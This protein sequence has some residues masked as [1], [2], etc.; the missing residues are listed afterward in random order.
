[1]PSNST[2]R[3]IERFE[4]R[5]EEL[6]E[7][8]LTLKLGFRWPWSKR[9]PDKLSL[10]MYQLDAK[11]H[12]GRSFFGNLSMEEAKRFALELRP[13]LSNYKLPFLPYPEG[14]FKGNPAVIGGSLALVC[15]LE[16]ERDVCLFFP[17]R[18]GAPLR[19]SWIADRRYLENPLYEP[20]RNI[21]H[22][23]VRLPLGEFQ[24]IEPKCQIGK[25]SYLHCQIRPAGFSQ[26]SSPAH[27]DSRSIPPR[28][29]PPQDQHP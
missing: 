29:R 22:Y 15:G 2:I 12:A 24:T 17:R 20:T 6:R 13:L 27:E 1:M 26:P 10:I 23:L 28:R 14:K 4:K 7:R 3:E 18:T 9:L 16:P 11:I 19:K 21:D 8:K 5:L 25:I